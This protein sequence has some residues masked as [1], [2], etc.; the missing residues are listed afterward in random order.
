MLFGD[1]ADGKLVRDVSTT[2][3]FMPYIMPRRGDAAL[4]MIQKIDVS[5]TQ[6]YLERWNDGARPKLSL[7]HI[8]LAAYVRMYGDHPDFNGFIAGGR[9]YRRNDVTISMAVLK[10]RGDDARATTVKQTYEPSEGLTKTG[11]RVTEIIAAGRADAMTAAEREMDLLLRLPGWLISIVLK[12]QKIGDWLNVT[13]VM[14]ARNDPL[15]ASMLVA[16]HGSVGLDA[17]YHHLFEHGT[18]SII[19]AI[20]PVRDEVV[21]NDKRETEVRPILTVRYSGDERVFEG[22]Y[23]ASSV[24]SFKKYVESPWLLETPDDSGP[25]APNT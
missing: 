23:A 9:L 19:S 11:R 25:G 16:F 8:I 17:A 5:E 22:H 2:R 24:A 13:P 7:V 21:V 20:G 1:R 18:I 6:A 15:Y 12:L 14:F 3:R 4:Y 10:S